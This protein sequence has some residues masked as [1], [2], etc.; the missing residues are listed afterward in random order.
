MCFSDQSKLEFTGLISTCNMLAA[1]EVIIESDGYLLWTT[2]VNE[3]AVEQR[4][5]Q[6]G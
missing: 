2:E 6:L 4:L 3:T 1:D 5:L